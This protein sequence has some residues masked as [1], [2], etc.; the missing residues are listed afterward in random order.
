MGGTT[1]GPK[2]VRAPQFRPTGTVDGDIVE[3]S[4][5]TQLREMSAVEI[6]QGKLITA[7]LSTV[8]RPI[9]HALGRRYKGWIVVD[10]TTAFIVSR[11]STDSSDPATHVALKA[12]GTC[13]VTIWIF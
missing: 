2:G 12:T 1:L 4:N 13:T 10:N 11:D 5:R 9:S 8:T 7:D 3:R 6:V